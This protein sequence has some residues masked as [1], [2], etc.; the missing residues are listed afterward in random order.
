MNKTYFNYAL[1][2]M[3]RLKKISAGVYCRKRLGIAL[4][5]IESCSFKM[6]TVCTVQ[7][8][9]T[10]YICILCSDFRS[11]V[12]LTVVCK[13]KKNILEPVNYL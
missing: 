13:K 1:A 7:Y 9:R 2:K 5:K 6:S 4:M 11:K 8:N 10:R 12:Y 3:N